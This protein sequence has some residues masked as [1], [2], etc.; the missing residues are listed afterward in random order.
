MTPSTTGLTILLRA[1]PKAIQA[2]L[3]GVSHVSRVMV[4]RAMRAA[5]ASSQVSAGALLITPYTPARMKTTV[6]VQPKERLDG[7]CGVIGAKNTVVSGVALRM[8]TVR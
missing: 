7:S 8:A 3:S 1:A 4:T 5:A 6:K 2:R